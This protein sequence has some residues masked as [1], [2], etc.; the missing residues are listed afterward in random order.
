MIRWRG[1]V[2]AIHCMSDELCAAV[3][4]S[5]MGIDACG[6]RN[7]PGD[8]GAAQTPAKALPGLSDDSRAAVQAI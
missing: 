3:A 5:A 8:E 2:A 7:E 6:F 1:P 4:G